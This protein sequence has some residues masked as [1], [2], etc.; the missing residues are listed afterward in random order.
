M[1][2]NACKSFAFVLCPGS[3]QYIIINYVLASARDEL[4]TVGELHIFTNLLTCD[5]SISKL[6]G[7]VHLLHAMPV[8]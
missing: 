6:N 8:H 5:N 7:L 3:I 2:L 1:F 4:W